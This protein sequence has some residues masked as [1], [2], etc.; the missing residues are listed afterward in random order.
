MET[1]RRIHLVSS[2]ST[3]FLVPGDPW[4]EATMSSQ[5]RNAESTSHQPIGLGKGFH[6]SDMGV[7]AAIEPTIKNVQD[8][9]LTAMKK[10]L[11]AW[12]PTGHGGPIKTPRPVPH[13]FQGF[14]PPV[15][16]R[17]INAWFRR[18]GGL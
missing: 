8:E 5:D 17:P 14:I 18:V 11:S 4:R 12:K 13:P 3:N 1:V 7:S 15:I 2:A 6:C 10:W 9:A 16:I